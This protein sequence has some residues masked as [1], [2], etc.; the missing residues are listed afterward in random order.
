MVCVCGGRRRKRGDEGG[1]Q[2]IGL[3]I[4]GR[5]DTHEVGGRRGGQVVREHWGRVG[6][7][8]IPYQQ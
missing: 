2:V 4:L 1:S 7:E 6:E 3:V 8:G 5:K